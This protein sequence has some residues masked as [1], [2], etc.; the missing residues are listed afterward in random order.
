MLPVHCGHLTAGGKA[1]RDVVP[2]TVHRSA[3][4]D[5][6]RAVSGLCPSAQRRQRHTPH[7]ALDPARRA[8]LPALCSEPRKA[9]PGSVTHQGCATSAPDGLAHHAERQ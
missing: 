1:R 6:V 9:A 5:A 8:R 3:T 7:E 4:G 2:S